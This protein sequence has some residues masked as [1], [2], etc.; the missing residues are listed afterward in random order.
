MQWTT[1]GDRITLPYVAPEDDLQ[2]TPATIKALAEAI[3][4]ELEATSSSSLPV[5]T[6]IQAV[7]QPSD[8]WILCDGG[9]Y[10]KADIGDGLF[11]ALQ[12]Y[13]DHAGISVGD[14]DPMPVP[15]LRGRVVIGAGT[16][17]HW[18]NN[19]D[20]PIGRR[21][22]DTRY[23]AH[24][25]VVNDNS[26]ASN[27]TTQPDG[28]T[29]YE[30]IPM[31]ANENA[32]SGTGRGAFAINN[33]TRESDINRHWTAHAYSEKTRGETGGSG[34][35]PPYAVIPSFIY[36]GKSGPFTKVGDI[37]DTYPV[38]TPSPVTTL[39]IAEGEIPVAPDVENNPPDG[40]WE[41]S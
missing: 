18:S 25:H 6:I 21:G 5:G 29:K 20:R 32:G 11:V 39:D 2:S 4:V 19:V 22:G 9:M 23:Q 41:A 26:Y 10:A 36:A 12:Q 1:T 35:L 40:Y 30:G 3:V 8:L 38:P 7:A 16:D 14:S 13:W 15:D 31:V 17:G 34:N 24:L 27:A 33:A 28:T 37:K